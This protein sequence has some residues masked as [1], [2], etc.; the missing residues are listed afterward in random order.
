[1]VNILHSGEN[2]DKLNIIIEAAQKRFGLYG[3]QKTS[4]REIASDLNMSKGS[5]YYYFPDKEYLYKAVVE[6]EQNEFIR[7]VKEKIQSVNDP[8][9]MLEEYVKIKLDYFRTL[10]NLSRFSYDE[11]KGIKPFMSSNWQQFRKNETEIIKEILNSGVT[12]GK[13]FIANIDETTD[14]FLDIIKG[15]RDSIISKK[16]LFYLELEE[17]ETLVKKVETFAKIFLKGLTQP[18]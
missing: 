11:F 17:Y 7:M 8:S 2:L 3:L 5:L 15:L 10:L 4:M 6:K 13:F 14:L 18:H 16:G 12:K 1:M 9:E